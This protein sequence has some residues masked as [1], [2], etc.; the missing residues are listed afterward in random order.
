MKFR[1][2]LL[3]SFAFLTR[4]PVP[5]HGY[6]EQTLARAAKFFPFVGFVVA[7]LAYALYWPLTGHVSVPAQCAW[8][9]CWLVLLTGGFHEDGLADAADGF[10]GAWTRE[11]VLDIMRDSRIG[12]YGALALVLSLLL[13]FTLLTSLNSKHLWPYLAGA[14]ILCR[15]STLPLSFLLPPARSSNSK[16]ISIAKKVSRS[17][18]FIGTGITV[19]FCAFLLKLA[20]FAPLLLSLLVIS[21]SAAYYRYR[22]GGITGDCFGA[23][24]QLV[25]ITTY[26]CG[27]WQ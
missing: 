27:V 17:S 26:L 4:L 2:D 13:R 20:F 19:V 18:L 10:G 22:I 23:T 3:A 5:K 8:L 24:N 1:D 21:G 7:A 6:D 12:S 14:H 16:G 15:W 9:L 25:E 11:R